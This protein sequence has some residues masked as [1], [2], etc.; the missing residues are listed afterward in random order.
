[1]HSPTHTYKNTHTHIHTHTYRQTPAAPQLPAVGGSDQRQAFRAS[2]TGGAYTTA[3]HYHVAVVRYP[4]AAAS[5]PRLPRR[6]C[7]LWLPLPLVQPT[8]DGGRRM[9]AAVAAEGG[10]IVSG[11]EE[12]GGV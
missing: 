2:G 5:L 10:E 12:R 11:G 4:A 6:P 3:Q 7:H 8:A 1:M 9:A